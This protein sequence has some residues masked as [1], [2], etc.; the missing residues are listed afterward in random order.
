[1]FIGLGILIAQILGISLCSDDWHIMLS[2]PVA[3]AFGS[4]LLLALFF[5][6]SPRFLVNKNDLSVVRKSLQLFRSDLDVELELNEV[7]R[8]AVE[9]GEDV[10]KRS[11]VF[12]PITSSVVL[13]MAQHFTGFFTVFFI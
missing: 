13:A 8:E 7:Y 6:E 10:G 2:I 11:G 12:W 9:K 3:L 5:P 4:V 1:M